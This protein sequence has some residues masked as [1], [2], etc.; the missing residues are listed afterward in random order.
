M[1]KSTTISGIRYD[2]DRAQPLGE[3][4]F[5][6]HPE[7]HERWRA[8]FCRKTATGEIFIAGSSGAMTRF[9]CKARILVL[10]PAERAQL[11]ER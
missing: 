8:T 4:G 10:S 11:I 1:C 9:K 2:T 3:V 7:D 5:G 6:E